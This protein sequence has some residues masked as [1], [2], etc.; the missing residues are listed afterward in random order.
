M[1]A[2]LFALWSDIAPAGFPAEPRKKT[3]DLL[4]M[5]GEENNARSSFGFRAGRVHLV[6]KII[7]GKFLMPA[8]HLLANID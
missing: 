7:S 8:A 6:S 3:A 4:V 2:R 1:G 5:A